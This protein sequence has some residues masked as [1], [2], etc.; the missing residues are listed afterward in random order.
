MNEVEHY[1][2]S[3]LLYAL[4][5]IPVGVATLARRDQKVGKAKRFD[6]VYLLAYFPAIAYGILGFKFIDGRY[7]IWI[8]G[9][10][11]V[12]GGYHFG[13]LL[14]TSRDELTMRAVILVAMALV[15]LL[16]HYVLT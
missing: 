7:L 8:L 5:G 2:L 4:I 16:Y 1:A 6:V 13:K 11:F 14:A 3:L 9:V 15:P 12:G 10:F